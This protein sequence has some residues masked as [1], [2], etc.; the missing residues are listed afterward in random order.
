MGLAVGCTIALHI[1]S[2]AYKF[3]GNG[4]RLIFFSSF[5]LANVDPIDVARNI[6]G[7]V[8]ETTLGNIYSSCTY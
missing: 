5:S 2:W 1:S 8:P 3:D 6:T 4:V 7:L